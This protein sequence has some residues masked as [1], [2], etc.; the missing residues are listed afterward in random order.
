M[1]DYI[2]EVCDLV[3]NGAGR[4][5]FLAAEWETR[6]IEQLRC[7][8]RTVNGYEISAYQQA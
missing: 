3:A 5:Q 7:A 6:E 8:N 1:Y 4:P 2:G